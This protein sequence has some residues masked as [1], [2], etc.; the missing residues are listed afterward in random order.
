MGVDLPEGG[1]GPR[2]RV[3][4]LKACIYTSADVSF[5]LQVEWIVRSRRMSQ[6]NILVGGP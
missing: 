4:T 2:K 1:K 6:R 5:L 3:S